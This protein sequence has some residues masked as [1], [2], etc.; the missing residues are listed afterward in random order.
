MSPFVAHEDSLT[1]RCFRCLVGFLC[2]ELW[3][4]DDATF[5]CGLSSCSI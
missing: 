1:N 4:R 5:S 3:S 2:V